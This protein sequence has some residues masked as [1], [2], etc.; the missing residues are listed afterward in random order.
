[1][2]YQ[3]LDLLLRIF[4]ALIALDVLVLAA[5]VVAFVWLFVPYRSAQDWQE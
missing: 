1:M 3:V 5:L 2:Y 4:W